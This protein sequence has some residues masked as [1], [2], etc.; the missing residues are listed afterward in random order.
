MILGN[1]AILGTPMN[2][3]TLQQQKLQKNP[4]NLYLR[5]NPGSL[6]ILETLLNLDNQWSLD[7]QLILENQRYP[8]IQLILGTLCLQTNLGTLCLQTNL[9]SLQNLDNQWSLDNQLILGTLQNLESLRYLET[10]HNLGSLLSLENQR[11]PGIQL[12]LGTLCL[13]TN[14]GTLYLQT[15]LGTLYLQTNLESLQNPDSQDHLAILGNQ[16]IPYI[17][18]QQH[19]HYLEILSD[20]QN[21]CTQQLLHWLQNKHFLLHANHH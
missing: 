4:D 17:L 9:E 3:D 1:L 8:G 11:Y 15:N 18:I 20:Q 21:H 13:Q 2:L 7:N 12:I 14:L 10:L 5:T 19:L 6:P 16:L